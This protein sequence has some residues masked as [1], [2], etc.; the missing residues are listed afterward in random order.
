MQSAEPIEILPGQTVYFKVVLA[1]T[2]PGPQAFAFFVHGN[3]LSGDLIS[4]HLA[5]ETVLLAEEDA[6]QKDAR[7]EQVNRRLSPQTS[8]DGDDVP[9]FTFKFTS[10]RSL[11]TQAASAF[12]GIDSEFTVRSATLR[13]VGGESEDVPVHIVYE[14]NGEWSLEFTKH[15]RSFR[16]GKY[17]LELTMKEGFRTYEDTIDF[18][19]GVLAVNTDKTVYEPNEPVRL[20]M[21][22]LDDAGNTICNAHLTLSISTPEGSE[23]PVAVR[24]SGVCGPN[25]VVDVADYLADYNATTLGRYSVTL[26]HMTPEGQLLHR[27]TDSFEVREQVPFVVTR[28]GPTRIYP[29]APY[30]MT[31][32]VAARRDFSG[33]VEE[34]LP[35]GTIV[36]ED[37]GGDFAQFGDT[38]RLS[39]NVEM[40][41]GESRTFTY[42]FDAADISPYL[43]VFGPLVLREG[44][45]KAFEE[46]RSWKVASDALGSYVEKYQAWTPT[47]SASWEAKSLASAPF[48]VPAGA[49]V[50]VAVVNSD[51]A[52]ERTGGVRH[53]S[54]TLTRSFLI[55]EAE[56]QGKTVTIMHVQ[57]SATSSIQTYAEDTTNI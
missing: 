51:T 47:A 55:H 46:L 40:L 41:A 26:S 29:K 16:P 42:T 53:A 28:T 1:S 27:I 34:F 17:T 50:E 56:P 8:F 57:A 32:T 37:H 3:T 21:A 49:V 5:E 12:L 48:S 44:E 30:E 11:L 6:D 23:V 15:P 31:I 9:K 14:E 43:Y 35:L 54:S 33:A 36:N 10:Q 13:H 18:Y 45:T 22:A 2:A 25:N 38:M 20:M 39:W 19:W 52:N 7:A 4:T 24:E